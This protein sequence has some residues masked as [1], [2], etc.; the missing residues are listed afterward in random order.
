MA[1]ASALC[2]NDS[3]HHVYGDR[4][5]CQQTNDQCGAKY[6]LIDRIRLGLGEK[7]QSHRIQ[8]QPLVTDNAERSSAPRD[9]SLA[10]FSSS[11]TISDTS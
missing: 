8:L 4:V 11:R 3:N 1:H 9:S 10:S 2:G 7:R 5:L 6:L